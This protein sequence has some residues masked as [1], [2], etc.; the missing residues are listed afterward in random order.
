VS[1]PG[2]SCSKV[3]RHIRF[4]SFER[5]AVQEEK[6]GRGDEPCPFA[7]ID[8]RMIAHDAIAV[9][10]SEIG[11]VRLGTGSPLRRP[12]QSGLEQP[13]DEYPVRRRARPAA[14]A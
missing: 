12:G 4:R 1:A 2:T 14:R 13:F 3:G 9:S 7:A 11:D 8:E 10:C 5:A 6:R